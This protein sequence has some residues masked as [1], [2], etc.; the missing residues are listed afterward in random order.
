[1]FHLIYRVVAVGVLAALFAAA[2]GAISL[3]SQVPSWLAPL[4]SAISAVKS[5]FAQHVDVLIVLAL[6]SAV[7]YIT[8]RGLE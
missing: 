5:A 7:A 3:P 2:L 8:W 4:H 6:V 1:M